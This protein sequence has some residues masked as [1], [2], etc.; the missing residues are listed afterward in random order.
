MTVAVA[1]LGVL[2]AALVQHGSYV[3]M[4]RE[5]SSDLR[6]VRRFAVAFVAKILLSVMLV[7]GY[8][9]LGGPRSAVFMLSYAA[10]FIVMTIAEAWV[11]SKRS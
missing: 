1:L 9:L 8:A 2:A 5:S 6:W 7:V 3:W 11:R 10:S 4:F